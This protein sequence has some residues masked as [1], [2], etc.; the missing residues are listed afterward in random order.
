MS[1]YEI[2]PQ[3]GSG[4]RVTA[5][6]ARHMQQVAAKAVRAGALSPVEKIGISGSARQAA[7]REALAAG[8]PIPD[9]TELSAKINNALSAAIDAKLA[10][11]AK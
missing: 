9:G 8:R 5:D 1:E 2:N 11:A 10:E 4:V 7:Y 6:S 3:A